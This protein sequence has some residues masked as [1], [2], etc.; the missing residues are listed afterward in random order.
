MSCSCLTHT[1][2][3]LALEYPF[4]IRKQSAIE[5][6]EEPEPES[7]ARKM[8]VWKLAEWLGLT[9]GVIKVFEDTECDDLRAPTSRQGIMEMFA[10]RSF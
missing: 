6:A 8:T 1:I 2:S 9:E 5:E 4:E 10:M 7:K 3:S